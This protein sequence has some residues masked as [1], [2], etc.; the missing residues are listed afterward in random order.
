MDKYF[1]RIEEIITKKKISARIKF[2]LQDVQETREVTHTHAHAHMYT[3]I[4]RLHLYFKIIS[5]CTRS[6]LCS[7]LFLF[8][9]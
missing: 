8:T 4:Y 1:M 2:M 9:E 6:S 5:D 7:N 3:Y